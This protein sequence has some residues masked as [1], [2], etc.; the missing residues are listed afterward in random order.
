MVG[1]SGKTKTSELWLLRGDD[2]VGERVG[3]FVFLFCP[4]AVSFSAAR[5]R[6][7][8]VTA[9]VV[10]DDVNEILLHDADLP[11]ACF[12]F[13]AFAGG[14]PAT[15]GWSPATADNIPTTFCDVPATS[16]CCP[17]IGVGVVVVAVTVVTIAGGADGREMTSGVTGRGG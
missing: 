10:D 12:D 4:S 7:R 3:R 16:D 5:F 8:V 15:T 2:G 1:R 14:F 9:A 6:F 13:G 17:A 11:D